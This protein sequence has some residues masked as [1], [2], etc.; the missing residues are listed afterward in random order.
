MRQVLLALADHADHSGFAFPSVARLAERLVICRRS[1]IY[2]LNLLEKDGWLKRSKNGR[3]AEYQIAVGRLG[4]GEAIA[5]VDEEKGAG[6]SPINGAA[7]APA[8]SIGANDGI[9]QV[10]PATQI[11]AN[12][13]TLYRKNRNE[14]SEEPSLGD[15][16]FPMGEKQPE[17]KHDDAAYVQ[18]WNQRCGSLPKVRKLTK[19]RK[20]LLANCIAEG[21]T[22]LQFEEVMAKIQASL[23]LNGNNERHWKVSFDWVIEDDNHLQK[24]LEGNYDPA[25]QPKPVRRDMP[26]AEEEISRAAK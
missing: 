22:L 11:G 14:P 18:M 20:S 9:G 10:Q 6:T 17:K 25:T 13:G 24:I 21:L 5:P 4:I 8:E 7:I 23:Y 16:L 2:A 15:A 3:R 12:G 1:V 19:K 26:D